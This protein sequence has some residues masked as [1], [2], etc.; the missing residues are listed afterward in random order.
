MMSAVSSGC[1]WLDRVYPE[2]RERVDWDRLDQ[3]DARHC[4][5][6]QLLD[7]GP[8]PPK[9]GKGS[10][11]RNGW[12]VMFFYLKGFL[13]RDGAYGWLREHGFMETTEEWRQ[14]ATSTRQQSSTRG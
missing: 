8:L 3:Q 10:T 11:P 2:W 13:E 5:L 4:I 6:G 14:W 1:D 9:G 7:P 12:D